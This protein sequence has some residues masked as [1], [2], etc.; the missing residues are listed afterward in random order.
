MQV[1]QVALGQFLDQVQP[2]CLLIFAIVH[3]IETAQRENA[4]THALGAPTGNGG[5]HR[6]E[7]NTGAVLDTAAITVL[8]LVGAGGEEL[9][10]QI[11]VSGMQ[12]DE[13]EV[14]LASIDRCL[15]EIGDDAGDLFLAQGTRY[16]GLSA[17]QVALLVTQRGTGIGR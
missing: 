14:G 6:F 3:A 8:A 9:V 12:F 5:I 4:D 17:Q 10:Q 11:A 15:A 13:V 1:G 16:G 7:H 2:C